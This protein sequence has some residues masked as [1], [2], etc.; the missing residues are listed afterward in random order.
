M[1]K[2]YIIPKSTVI[3]LDTD[4][5]MLDTSISISNDNKKGGG[6]AMTQRQDFINTPWDDWSE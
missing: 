2:K 4:F 3:N 6:D 5:L 1:N